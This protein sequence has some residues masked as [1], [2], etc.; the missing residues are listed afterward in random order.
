MGT[1]TMLR[2]LLQRETTWAINASALWMVRLTT[3]TALNTRTKKTALSLGKWTKIWRM[4]LIGA[5]AL[6]SLGTKKLKMLTKLTK[7]WW[8]GRTA[9]RETDSTWEPRKTKRV[10]LEPRKTNSD[11]RSTKCSTLLTGLISRTRRSTC[12]SDDFSQILM[13]LWF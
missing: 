6:A 11:L 8:K 4:P 5:I 9:T 10:V 7:S 13:T 3:A 2:M 1:L 12:V